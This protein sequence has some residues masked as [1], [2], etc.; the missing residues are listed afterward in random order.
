MLGNNEDSV[1]TILPQADL[2]KIYERS[3]EKEM[4]NFLNN[5]YDN[6]KKL[7][8]EHPKFDRE[9]IM[10]AT[11][12]L[13]EAI[14]EDPERPGLV[15]TPDRVARMWEEMF[16]GMAYSN[17]D[18]AKMFNTCFDTNEDNEDLVTIMN[19]PV[20]STCEHHL[21]LMYD[22]T[23]SIGY[24]PRKGKVIGLSKAARVAEMCAHRV[25]LQEKLG[26]DIA[27]VMMKILDTPDVIVVIRGKHSC[28]TARGAKSNAVTKTATLKGRFKTVSDLRKEFYSLLDNN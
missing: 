21:A 27:D 13:L 5:S 14:G 22:M 8:R 2:D 19:I 18:I 17:D 25:Q 10:K 9:K 24:I 16:E 11:T 20:F 15:G 1:L 28:M 23:V 6:K 7:N 26:E 4:E 12:M 3:K